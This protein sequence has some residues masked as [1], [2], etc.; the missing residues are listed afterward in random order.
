MVS[1]G[2]SAFLFEQKQINYL[3]KLIMSYL[4]RPIHHFALPIDINVKKQKYPVAIEI[5]KRN[6]FCHKIE[7]MEEEVR[8][9]YRGK[10]YV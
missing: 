1:F 7:D 6:S 2:A 5:S 4:C 9:F 10:I 3:K 8:F